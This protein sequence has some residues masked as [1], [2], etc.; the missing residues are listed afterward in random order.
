MAS[1]STQNG[2]LS[3]KEISMMK[4]TLLQLINYV[5]DN[6]HRMRQEDRK[7]LANHL[8]Y[9]L[10]TLGN[11]SNSLDV[12]MSQPCWGASC[13]TDPVRPGEKPQTKFM[14]YNRDGTS[15]VLDK[16]DLPRTKDDWEMQ[17]DESLLLRPPCYQMPPQNV[18]DLGRLRAM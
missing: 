5:D 3:M 6:R 4:G 11:M 1:L 13:P 16:K 9:A 18:T 17:F 14:M 10:N 12:Q 2:P 8:N 15:T 7:Q